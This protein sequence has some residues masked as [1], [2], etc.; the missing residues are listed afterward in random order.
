MMGFYG[1]SFVSVGELLK[2]LQFWPQNGLQRPQN[3][4]QRPQDGLGGLEKLNFENYIMIGFFGMNLVS[5]GDLL[6]E[7]QVI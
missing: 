5:V 3:G 6:K 7:L 4:H 2:E 1:M